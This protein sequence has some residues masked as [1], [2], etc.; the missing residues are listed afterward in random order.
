MKGKSIPL[1]HKNLCAIVRAVPSDYTDY[2]GEVERWAD[3]RASYPDCSYECRWAAWLKGSLGMDWLI[4]GKPDGPRRG[5]LTFEHQAG[6]GCFE[7]AP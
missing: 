2:G 3:P 4:C 1:T 5:M 6:H 7:A